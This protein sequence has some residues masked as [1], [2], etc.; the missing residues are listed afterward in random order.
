MELEKK[1]GLEG[2]KI[3]PCE[4]GPLAVPRLLVHQGGSTITEHYQGAEYWWEGARGSCAPQSLQLSWVVQAG[5]RG[6]QDTICSLRTHRAVLPPVAPW[7]VSGR[8]GQGG[9]SDG[10]R[11]EHQCR[12]ALPVMSPQHRGAELQQGTA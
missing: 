12:M 5:P 4:A 2:D 11:L 6:A 7:A 10:E 3:S 9:E 1:E 8:L